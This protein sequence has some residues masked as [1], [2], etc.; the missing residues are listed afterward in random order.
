MT[1]PPWAADL[2]PGLDPRLVAAIVACACC[3]RV[4]PELLRSVLARRLE[5]NASTDVGEVVGD[6]RAAG[7]PCPPPDP[8]AVDEA[9]RGLLAAG[10]RVL[11]VGRRGYPPPLAQAWPELGAPAWL[12]VR[13]T[14][15][16]AAAVAVVGTRRPTLD[17]LHTARAL[18]RFLAEAGVC[19]VSGMA[20]GIDQAAHAGAIDGGGRTVGVL[21]TGFGVDYPRGDGPVRDAV[22]ASGALVTEYAPGAPPH[23]H[24]FPW[25][26]RIIS[27][28]AQAVVVVEGQARS[29]AL[30]TA[31]LAASQGREV[32]AAPGSLNAPT[33]RGPLALV[34]DG[35]HV[36]TRFE[37]VLEMIPSLPQGADRGDAVTG[38]DDPGRRAVWGLL[39]T[40]PATA[41][42]LA[43][44]TGAS[45]PSVL[46]V[47]AELE[48][49]GVVRHTARGFVRVPG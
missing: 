41:G 12:F 30:Q 42:A 5:R 4:S 19:V 43:A 48:A 20:R 33:S 44:A 32:F 21:G 31:R 39:G 22:A 15:P 14:V 16:L 3:P 25:R 13:G 26:N 2:G 37:D 17:G 6:L 24:H 8:A 35:A 9:A 40:Q 36:L 1:I 38:V 23:P 29:G 34:R 27:G 45:L 28:L 7:T 11:A 47:L 49:G 10:A 18:G 46:R